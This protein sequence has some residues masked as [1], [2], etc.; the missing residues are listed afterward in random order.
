MS[1][2]HLIQG[3]RALF[4][5]YVWDLVKRWILIPMHNPRPLLEFSREDQG[6][7]KECNVLLVWRTGP[8]MFK[9]QLKDSVQSDRACY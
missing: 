4:C 5:S 3:D 1:L 8:Q 2:L 9:C 7:L 6:F